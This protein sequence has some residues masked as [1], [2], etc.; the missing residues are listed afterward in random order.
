MHVPTLKASTGQSG[1]GYALVNG[2]GAIISWQVPNDGQQHRFKIY[3][4]LDVT[5]SETGG[6]IN[7]TWTYPN[8]SNDGAILASGGQE[9]GNNA[10]NE[11]DRIVESG[12]VITVK[13]QTAL[14]LGAAI[15][16]AEIWGN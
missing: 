5:S 4:S 1:T 13:Q 12:S 6:Q 10:V 16:W 8:G 9:S 2:T 11:I 14:T 3:A 7:V 15:L